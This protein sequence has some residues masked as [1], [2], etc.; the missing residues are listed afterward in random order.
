[1]PVLFIGWEFG[2]WGETE[3]EKTGQNETKAKKVGVRAKGVIRRIWRHDWAGE[4]RQCCASF[5]LTIFVTAS[6][7]SQL[8]SDGSEFARNSRSFCFFLHFLSLFLICTCSVQQLQD[9][10][11]LGGFF[12]PLLKYFNLSN[13]FK[14]TQVVQTAKFA[15]HLVWTQNFHQW[16]N[17]KPVGL[18]M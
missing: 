6:T 7:F 17:T 13:C 14:S 9:K 5:H 15:S 18:R 4:W 8:L 1:M 11:F 2:R 16:M 10:C 12:V 3:G